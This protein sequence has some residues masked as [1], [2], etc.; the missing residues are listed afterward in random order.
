MSVAVSLHLLSAVIW[1]GGMFFAYVV[2]RPVAGASLE[3]SARLVFWSKIFD[4]FFPWVWAAVLLLL[5]SGY[6]MVFKY[7][8]GF[9]ALG[10]D[11]HIMQGIGIIMMLLFMHLYFAP[12]RRLKAAVR[13][14]DWADGARRLNQIRQIVAINTVLGLSL[15]VIGSGGRYI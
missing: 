13:S 3:Q 6:F 15:I 11:I 12:Y 2:L 8:G 7:L 4:R 5:T 1:V 10:L 9:A 14:E